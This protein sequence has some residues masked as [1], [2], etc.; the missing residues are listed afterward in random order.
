MVSN[1]PLSTQEIADA[2]GVCP[3]GTTRKVAPL[4]LFL[5][6]SMQALPCPSRRPDRLAAAMLA[7]IDTLA[8]LQAAHPKAVSDWIGRLAD[9][10]QAAES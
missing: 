10:S 7:R 1:L 2:L 5:L 3:T 6:E 8:K 9:S 4:E